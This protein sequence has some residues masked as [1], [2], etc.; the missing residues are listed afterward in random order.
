MTR[1]SRYEDRHRALHLCIK[2]Q[3]PSW[4]AEHDSLRDPQKKERAGEPRASRTGAA[5]FAGVDTVPLGPPSD[6]R[7]KAALRR[8][9]NRSP[10]WQ[11]DRLAYYQEWL[12]CGHSHVEFLAGNPGERRRCQ[13]CLRPHDRA[14]RNDRV[15]ESL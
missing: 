13:E 10:V 2:C 15:E 12:E 3:R 1:Q 5:Y 4:S 8:I 7:L 6:S 11:D 9:V 14:W